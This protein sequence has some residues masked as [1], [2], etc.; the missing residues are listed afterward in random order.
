VEFHVVELGRIETLF[1]AG[2]FKRTRSQTWKKRK[3][4]EAEKLIKKIDKLWPFC[5]VVLLFLQLTYA[6]SN[7]SSILDCRSDQVELFLY[8]YAFHDPLA[9]AVDL[10]ACETDVWHSPLKALVV[11]FSTVGM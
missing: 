8:E 1:A 9:L 4:G 5:P 10:Q 3:L 11:C 7:E 2:I 6:A